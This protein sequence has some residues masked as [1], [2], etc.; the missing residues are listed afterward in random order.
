MEEIKEDLNK[1][2]NAI[3]LWVRRLYTLKMSILPRSVYRYIK[4]PARHLLSIH[5][6]MLNLKK[7]KEARKAEIILKKKNK[8]EDQSSQL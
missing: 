5:S 4:S 7:S 1:W 6:I 2:R 3:Y 8:W